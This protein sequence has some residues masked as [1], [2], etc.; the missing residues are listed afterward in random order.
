MRHASFWAPLNLCRDCTHDSSLL[1]MSTL[2][3]SSGGNLGCAFLFAFLFLA[4]QFQ[5][6]W[7]ITSKFLKIVIPF[8]V[9]F[10]LGVTFHEFLFAGTMF[11]QKQVPFLPLPPKCN[12]SLACRP[13]TSKRCHT[14]QHNPQ[15]RISVAATVSRS[16]HL[17][18]S[19]PCQILQLACPSLVPPSR[20]SCLVG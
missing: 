2:C 10:F 6:S 18:P 4:F 19:L 11:L 16:S 12:N 1:W 14:Q 7:A 3:N 9:L 8:H 5:D 15:Q 13:K 17:L 20:P